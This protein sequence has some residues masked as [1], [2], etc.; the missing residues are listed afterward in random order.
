M[1]RAVERACPGM[2][3]MQ[4][5]EEAQ[6]KWSSTDLVLDDSQRCPV[7]YGLLV[8]LFIPWKDSGS[9]RMRNKV[10]P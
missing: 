6:P 10:E 7:L 8:A 1:G 5:V 4:A 3:K 9:E 2:E